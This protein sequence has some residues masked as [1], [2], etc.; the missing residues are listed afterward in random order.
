MAVGDIRHQ[1]HHSSNQEKVVAV[2]FVAQRH[3][4]DG[5]TAARDCLQDPCRG[6][7][8]QV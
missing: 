2:I 6:Y 4:L 8:N 1:H 7:D 3:E 5:Y